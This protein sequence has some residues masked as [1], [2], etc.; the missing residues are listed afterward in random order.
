ML[1]DAIERCPDE[2]W[3]S[4]RH[5]NA[6]WQIAYHVIFFTHLYLMPDEASFRPWPGHQFNVQHEDGIP[7]KADPSSSLPLI[8]RPYSRAEALA[9]WDVCDSLVDD[10]VDALDLASPASGFHWYSMSKLEHQIMNIRH[11]QHHTAQLADRLR[12]ELQTGIAWVAAGPG[13]SAAQM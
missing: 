3:L 5:T 8:P 11:L 13:K 7:G 2:V 12:A 4:A 1:R 9:Y 10:T 6:F